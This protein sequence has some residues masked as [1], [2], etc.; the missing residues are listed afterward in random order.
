MARRPRIHY[1]GAV[2]H[3]MLR[4]NG[5]QD[6]FF[7]S[8]DR[9]RFYL[10]VQEGI[11]KYGHRIHAFC[12]MTNHVHLLIQVADVPLSKIIQNLSFRY[13][14]Y[15]HKKQEKTGHLFQGRYKAILVDIDTYLIQLVRY[16]HSNPVRADI[17]TSCDKYRWSSHLTYLGKDVTPW[18]FTD[19]V[20]A[21]FSK[22]REKARQRYAAFVAQREKEEH[23]PEFSRGSYEGR[24]LGNDRFIE[25]AFARAHEK[26]QAKFSLEEAL[27]AV[28]RV[29]GLRGYE[30][31]T[32]S[33][34]SKLVEARAM[35]AVV[36]RE[37]GHL[38][39]ADL[40]TQLG[41]DLSGLSQGAG[42]LERKLQGN[43][44]LKM[45]LDEVRD[46]LNMPI[47]QA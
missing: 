16:I 38:M 24:L 45:R 29:Y 21:R 39:L 12:L 37:S 26:I 33:R 35:A 3:V 47:C 5:G 19:W 41:R 15:I 27:E 22:D 42:R 7:S 44:E 4:G 25:K 8:S 31:R 40:A 34:R 6:I 2:Y 46:I 13:T 28:C 32:R 11:E 9:Y 36:V 23:R 43:E 18:L 17:V 10:L 30:L 1:P 14:R 20:L